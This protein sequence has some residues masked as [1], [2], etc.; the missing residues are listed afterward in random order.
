MEKSIEKNAFDL[1]GKVAMVT[2]A[3]RGMG[4]HIA[5]TLAQ[6]GADLI[7]CSRTESEL[8]EVADKIKARGR[9]AMVYPIDLT[10]IAA[11]E[12]MVA[13]CED[14]MGGIDV[15]VN[16]AGVNIP[17]WAE[18]VT[19][20]AWDTVITINLKAQFFCAQAVGR[21]M[22][23]R[24]RG[25]IIMVSSQ[26]GSVGLIKRAAYCSSK[27]ALNQLTRTLAI[28]W[29]KHN[30]TVNA[31]APTFVEGPFTEPMFKD[32]EFKDYVLGN[33]PL[34]RI[35]QAE[36]VSGAVVYLASDAANLVTGS[37]LAIDGG[38]TAQ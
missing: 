9:K 28:E 24:K 19:E 30:V 4:A 14:D 2:G 38:W 27:G 11:I 16:N 31:I 18:D 32:K 37:V 26:A 34:G 23:E 21:R 10:D 1:T 5:Q 33:I 17:Q 35:G 3:G 36:D 8:T 12:E 22:I 25:K 13:A 7:I 15:L 29:A 20:E 6:Y